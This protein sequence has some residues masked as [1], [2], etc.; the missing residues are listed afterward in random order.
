MATVI[1][2]ISARKIVVPRRIR[3]ATHPPI[4]VVAGIHN[5]RKNDIRR[6][7]G[8]EQLRDYQVHSKLQRSHE[9]VH[10]HSDA[11]SDQAISAPQR[12]PDQG[13]HRA[14]GLTPKPTRR[15]GSRRGFDAKRVFL[16]Q[17]AQYGLSIGVRQNRFEKPASKCRRRAATHIVPQWS[18]N[19]AVMLRIVCSDICRARLPAPSMRKSRFARP[20]RCGVG[21]PVNELT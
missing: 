21:S 4:A 14:T 2:T 8:S 6:L 1:V 7:I 18:F 12:V 11:H 5:R 9:D 20:P 3:A 13:R 15:D 17:V 16:D 10:A 19:P